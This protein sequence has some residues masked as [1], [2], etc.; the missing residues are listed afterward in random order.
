M[1]KNASKRSLRFASR[2]EHREHHL[3]W[4][5]VIFFGTSV[6]G[7]RAVII[8][9]GSVCSK[10]ANGCSGRGI[11]DPIFA[12]KHVNRR[13]DAGSVGRPTRSIV[14]PRRAGNAGGNKVNGIDS[15]NVN[16][17]RRQL[18]RRCRARV[19]AYNPAAIIPRIGRAIGRVATNFSRCRMNIRVSVFAA[20]R[21]VWLCVVCSIASRGI[22]RGIAARAVSG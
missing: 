21:A 2:L 14:R 7:Q 22:R 10:D 13:L 3:P 1:G 6:S 20:S 8:G 9:P 18:T 17:K 11:G 4:T 19:S 12:V 15:G 5:R 16:G